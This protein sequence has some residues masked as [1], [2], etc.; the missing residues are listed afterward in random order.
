MR[1]LSSLLLFLFSSAARGFPSYRFHIPNGHR[2][3]CPEGA[4]GCLP[5]FQVQN[6][7]PSTCNGLGHT[8]CEGGS[9]PLNS[10]GESLTAFGYDWT[11]ELCQEDSDG[12]GQTNGEELGDPC[13]N[14]TVGSMASD[15]MARMTPS[16][17][18]VA[19]HK[20]AAP[21]Q[22]PEC[23]ADTAPGRQ[24]PK[25]ASFNPGEE[26]RHVEY[27]IKNYTLPEKVT[28]YVDF[29]FNF[30]DES[31]DI[32]HIVYATV[33][34]DQERHLHHFVIT[35]CSEKIPEEEVGTARRGPH[36][37]CNKPLGGTAFWAPGVVMFTQPNSSGVPIGRGVD[38]VGINV[39]VHYTDAHLFP[40]TTSQD[41]FTVY[42][43]PTLRPM[44]A[45]S[46]NPLQI[47]TNPGMVIPPGK[48]RFF[49]TRSCTVLA[50]KPLPIVGVYYHAHLLG[51]EM[52]QEVLRD[53]QKI[54]LGSQP[55]W[56]YDDQAVFSLLDRDLEIR[57]GD[58]IQSTCV[59]DSSGR[60]ED[61]VMHLH[62]VTEMCFTSVITVAATTEPTS[63]RQFKCSESGNDGF[64]WLG[65]LADGEDA[66]LIP[67]NHPVS[68]ASD[69]YYGNGGLSGGKASYC[70]PESNCTSNCSLCGDEGLDNES[71]IAGEANGQPYTCHAAQEWINSPGATFGC[72]TAQSIWAPRCCARSPDMCRLCDPGWK[73][74]PDAMAGEND[75]V[76]YTCQAAHDFLRIPASSWGCR[77]ARWQLTSKCCERDATFIDA[78]PAAGSIYSML[79]GLALLVAYV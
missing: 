35:G 68:N 4:E 3:P 32:F 40:G 71:A 44:T 18:G 73:L 23:N 77:L 69:I 47:G 22:R 8:T 20:Q 55:I 9:L 61:T 39:N 76:E 57:P 56:H 34:I 7:P 6:Q 26:Q 41:G 75:G 10:F 46:S 30:D 36:S 15:Y 79:A 27:R 48:K 2:V 52:Y 59:Y 64:I 38:I 74:L 31:Q 60:T 42:Y 25:V 24:A 14:W 50:E 37:S 19:S 43:T 62:T 28:S 72:D 51:G 16:H 17:P 63:S 12:D 29:G 11:L 21:Y 5:G 65:E 66:L 70:P 53:G 33:L 1:A 13:C 67:D 54:D 78:A 58:K 45:F 49:V